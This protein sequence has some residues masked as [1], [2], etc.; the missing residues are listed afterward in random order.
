MGWEFQ[1]KS[2]QCGITDKPTTCRNP[3]ANAVRERL[4]QTVANILRT[5]VVAN[6]PRDLHQAEAAI[7]HALATA[8]HVMHCA[9]SRSLGTSPG[10]LVF[11]RYMLLDLPIIVDLYQIQQRRQTIIDENLMRQNRKR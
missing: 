9:V 8:M 5:T 7:D 11:R 10:A 1:N 2:T 3:Q 6:P 4:H